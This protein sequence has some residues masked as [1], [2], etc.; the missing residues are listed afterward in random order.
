VYTIKT[1]LEEIRRENMK[2][3]DLALNNS[4]ESGCCE[5]EREFF[6]SMKG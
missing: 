3:T 4:Q 5:N 2:Q 6:V 1:E